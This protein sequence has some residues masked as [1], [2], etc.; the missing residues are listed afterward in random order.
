MKLD[1]FTQAYLT[2][3]LWSTTDDNDDSLE[4]NYSIDDISESCLT[5]MIADCV[6][7]QAENMPMIIDDLSEAGHNFWLT[8][9]GHGAGFWDGDYPEHGET[10]TAKSKEFKEVELYVGDDGLIYC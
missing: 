4:D 10:L 6:K 9:N 7:F 3:A 2:T 5:A 8:R 1:T